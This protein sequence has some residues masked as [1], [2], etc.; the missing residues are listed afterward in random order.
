MRRA[1]VARWD[2]GAYP[3]VVGA[4]GTHDAVRHAG[5]CRDCQ[6]NS[7]RKSKEDMPKFMEVAPLIDCG[8]K[9]KPQSWAPRPPTARAQ[10]PDTGLKRYGHLTGDRSPKW[11]LAFFSRFI[12]YSCAQKATVG[13]CSPMQ[14]PGRGSPARGTPT[15][16][17]RTAHSSAPVLG[18][19]RTGYKRWSLFG[20]ETART[21]RKA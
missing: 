20:R 16:S 12:A 3:M 10:S 4:A 8:R 18:R 21:G 7:A 17:P 19:K 1:P 15:R 5:V 2:R 11:P 9:V 6:S 14:V 13:Y